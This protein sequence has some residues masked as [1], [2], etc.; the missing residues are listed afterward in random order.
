MVKGR[1]W[2][3]SPGDPQ[4]QHTQGGVSAHCLRGEGVCL[5]SDLATLDSKVPGPRVLT[6]SLIIRVWHLLEE[7]VLYA[8][9]LRERSELEPRDSLSVPGFWALHSAEQQV[10]TCVGLGGGVGIPGALGR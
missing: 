1:A 9:E 4:G 8:T 3:P 10:G 5:L 6:T 7:H 2:V